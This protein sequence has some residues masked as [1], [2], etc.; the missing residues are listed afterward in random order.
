MDI[1][2]ELQDMQRRLRQKTYRRVLDARGRIW[3]PTP[4]ERYEMDTY[5]EP[6]PMQ[7]QLRKQRDATIESIKELGRAFA[8]MGAVFASKE[9]NE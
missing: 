2:R 5:G 6:S 4:T 7:K 1:E 3:E 9:T 8:A